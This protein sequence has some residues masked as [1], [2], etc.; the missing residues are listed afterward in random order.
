M[1]IWRE[2]LAGTTAMQGRFTIAVC[3]PGD[4]CRIHPGRARAFRRAD[5][6]ARAWQAAQAIADVSAGTA[7]VAV[8]PL[9]SETEA[10]RDAWWTA[11]LHKDDA[12]HPRRRPPAVLG[13]APE[14]AP[15]VQALVVAA[16]APDPSGATAPCSAWN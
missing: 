16:V 3:E 6:A 9:P 7:A 15:D 2:L 8:L 5:A 10:P 11:L 13:A 1:R 4:G 12:A 14:G